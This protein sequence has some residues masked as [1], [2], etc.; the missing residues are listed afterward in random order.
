MEV[1]NSYL[2]PDTFL[3]KSKLLNYLWCFKNKYWIMNL[4]KQQVPLGSNRDCKLIPMFITLSHLNETIFCKTY[5]VIWFYSA[6][7]GSAFASVCVDPTERLLCSG[8]EDGSVM[9]YDIRSS[10]GMQSFRPH[11]DECRSA[12]FSMNALYLLSSSYDRKIV[13]TN[14]HGGLSCCMMPSTMSLFC[15]DFCRHKQFWGS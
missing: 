8:H 3:V 2:F 11:T 15:K 7:P 4:L 10:R 9:L 14:L 6:V 13:L 12:R 1:K 5:A